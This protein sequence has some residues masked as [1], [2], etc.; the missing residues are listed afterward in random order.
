MVYVD[1]IVITE[2]ESSD[3]ARLKQFLRIDFIPKTWANFDIFLVLKLLSLN[4]ELT[5]LKGNTFFI[6]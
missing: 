4:Y 2:T 1:D 6:C 3:I 5:Y